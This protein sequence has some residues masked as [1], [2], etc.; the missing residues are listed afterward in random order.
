MKRIVLGFLLGL[1]AVGPLVAQISI[2]PN[3]MSTVASA[4]Y[5]KYTLPGDVAVIINIWGTIRFSGRYELKRGSTLGDAVS[6]A[7]GPLE[8]GVQAGSVDRAITVT[9]SRQRFDRREIIFQAELSS[10]LESESL[11]PVLSEGDVIYINTITE[12]RPN[13]QT[14]VLPALNLVAT[15]LLIVLRVVDLGR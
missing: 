1:C 3:R 9:L 8:R 2:N 12:Q 10:V 15:S 14:L 6:L 5:Y 11:L 13:F 7:G 4:A